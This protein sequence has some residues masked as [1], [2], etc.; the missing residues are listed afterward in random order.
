M[1]KS[2]FVFT[3]MGAVPISG[4]SVAK[5]RLE[6]K[7]AK[8]RKE[9]G[10]DPMESWIPHDLRRTAATE[11]GRLGVPEFII[12]RVLNHAAK[13]VTGKVYNRYEYLKEKRDALDKWARYLE[14]LIR[15]APDNVV[16][17]RKVAQ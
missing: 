15:P 8:A 14:T 7:I 13:G 4:F 3:T 6:A 12:G 17:M 10:A 11:M 5:R 16:E 9:D 2:P 1:A